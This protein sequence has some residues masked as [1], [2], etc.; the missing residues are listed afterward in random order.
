MGTA[1]AWTDVSPPPAYVFDPGY[2]V[3]QESGQECALTVMETLY[4]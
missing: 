2:R 1:D 3:C 4:I